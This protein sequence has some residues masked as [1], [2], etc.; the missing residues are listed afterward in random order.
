MLMFYVCIEENKG[1][2]FTVTHVHMS[3]KAGSVFAASASATLWRLN[4]FQ[5]LRGAL[6]ARSLF[7]LTAIVS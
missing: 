6:T 2:T 1:K 4:C 7:C 3:T 5:A